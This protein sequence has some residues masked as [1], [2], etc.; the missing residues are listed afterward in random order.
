MYKMTKRKSNGEG[1]IYFIESQQRW[2]AEINWID[3][4]GNKR[5]KSWTATKQSDVKKKLT[6]FKKQFLLNGAEVTTEGRTFRQ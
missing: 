1:T 3:N 2:R 4:A 6:E 5:R